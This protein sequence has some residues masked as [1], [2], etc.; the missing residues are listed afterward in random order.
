MMYD[1]YYD[2]RFILRCTIYIM[3]YGSTNIKEECKLKVHH[4]GFGI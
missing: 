3:M 2:V 4:P 1:L